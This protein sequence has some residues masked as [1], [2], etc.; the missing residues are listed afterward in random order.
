MSG[1]GSSLST[2]IR[3]GTFRAAIVLAAF[4]LFW[5]IRQIGGLNAYLIN[6]WLV[7]SLPLVIA[8][9]GVTLVM[10][11]RQ[12]D[13]SAGG[14]VTL[15]NVLMATL[16]SEL[17]AW[18]AV[19]IA[20]ALGGA[21]G[22]INGLLVIRAKLPAIAVTLATLIVL[23]G[24]ALVILPSPGGLVSPDLVEAVTGDSIVPR[25][26]IVIA[27]IVIAWLIYRRTRLGIYAFAAG[28]DDEA[29]RLSG[30][31][32]PRVRLAIFVIAGG[33]YGLAGVFL[34]A[35]IATGDAKIGA[36]YMLQT[37]A[38][39]AIGGTA[40]TGGSGSVIGTILGATTMTVLPK[41]LFVA[42]INS[43][44]QKIATGV[45]V[46]IAVLIGAISG[47]SQ[48]RK[49]QTLIRDGA[50]GGATVEPPAIS[51]EGRAR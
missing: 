9:V 10:I 35:A 30:V 37:F 42:G 39:I 38:A 48:Q 14:V 15:I 18:L 6:S 47:R 16:L 27:V 44:S 28:Q 50:T 8:S 3:S 25:S 11:T 17:P 23:N 12:F 41:V 45:L 2:V 36:P 51:E 43:W 22:A 32:V 49:Q 31:S 1:L 40:F 20:V 19:L 21:I 26:F 46:I 4:V 13:L 33:L 5:A 29:L 7:L 24:L 34:S